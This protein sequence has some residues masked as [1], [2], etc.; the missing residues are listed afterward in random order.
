MDKKFCATHHLYYRGNECPLCLSE[1]ISYY[2]RK[3]N[4]TDKG[5]DD[6]KDKVKEKKDREINDDDL[7]KLVN[8]FNKR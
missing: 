6:E 3:Y 4:N 1:R 8:K 5:C 7:S 2:D